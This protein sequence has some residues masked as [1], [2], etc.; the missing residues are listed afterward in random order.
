MTSKDRNLKDIMS[1]E[2]SPIGDQ[3]NNVL[4]APGNLIRTNPYGFGIHSP[5]AYHLV[6][7]VLFGKALSFPGEKEA[8]AAL[9]YGDRSLAARILRLA[10]Y[11]SPELLLTGDEGSPLMATLTPLWPVLLPN[12]RVCSVTRKKD[13]YYSRPFP[14]G[15]QSSGDRSSGCQSS[16]DQ[17]SGCQSSADQSPCGPMSVNRL[18]DK[19]LPGQRP[20][21]NVLPGQRPSDNVLP[22]QRPSGVL[23]SD[24]QHSVDRSPEN[25]PPVAPGSGYESQAGNRKPRVETMVIGSLVCH[26]PSSLTR[27]NAPACWILTDL[28][29]LELKGFF[30]ILRLSDTTSL[31]FEVKKT[32]IVIF[33]PRFK[34]QNY[35]VREWFRF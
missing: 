8:L 7:R 9:R 4:Y 3:A 13:P 20:S 26:F 25:Q 10:R 19:L 15:D 30:N 14:A 21:D 12:T 24:P 17:P 28:G 1:P 6:A 32:G 11:F 29:N 34:K 5:F 2:N 27:V 16:G 33:D 23:P 18:S 22:G 35:F 31:T